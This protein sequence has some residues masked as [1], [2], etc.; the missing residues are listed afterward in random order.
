[1]CGSPPSTLVYLPLD[2]WYVNFRVIKHRAKYKTEHH[3]SSGRMARHGTAWHDNSAHGVLVIGSSSP[4]CY[5]M[6]FRVIVYCKNNNQFSH[7][8]CMNSKTQSLCPPHYVWTTFCKQLPRG[9]CSLAKTRMNK[10]DIMVNTANETQTM[11]TRMLL[12]QM[13]IWYFTLANEVY[14]AQNAIPPA[15]GTHVCTFVH[16][17]CHADV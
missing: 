15:C 13:Q 3:A 17:M 11:M 5:W 12:I 8:L 16:Y 10:Y 4:R 6:H 2:A 7:A 9:A 14:C 1:M